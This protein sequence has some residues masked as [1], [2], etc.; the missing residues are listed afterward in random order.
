MSPRTRPGQY[1]FKCRSD[2]Q[3]E[4]SREAMMS[5]DDTSTA[6]ECCK[7]VTGHKK[8]AGGLTSRTNVQQMQ[9]RT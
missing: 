5:S 2:V 1:K 9:I 8:H 6:N 7:S 4:R 3:Y